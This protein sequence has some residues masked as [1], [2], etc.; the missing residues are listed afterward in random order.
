MTAQTKTI[1]IPANLPA[2]ATACNF[3]V[4]VAIA[5]GM[6]EKQVHQCQL[7]VDEACT[8]II[9]HGYQAHNQGQFIDVTCLLLADRITIRIEDDSPA[10]N[11]LQRDDPEP[12]ADAA[13]EDRER[14]GWGVFFIKQV[15]DDVVY[16]YR[17]GRNQLD[18]TR[19]FRSETTP[20]STRLDITIDKQAQDI[21]L[22]GL[23]GKLNDESQGKLEKALAEHLQAGHKHFVLDMHRVQ[24]VSS[25]GWQVLVGAAQ[26]ARSQRGDLILANLDGPAREVIKLTGLDMV[27]TVTDS[28]AEALKQFPTHKNHK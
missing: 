8:N 13:L 3:V 4:K 26:R 24:A 11:P 2:V 25:T 28:V 20:Y 22:I 9:E 19:Y 12:D 15:M 14:G 23:Q 1:R 10:Y 27:F 6:D 7:A 21:V 18:M 17:D 16:H 5:A